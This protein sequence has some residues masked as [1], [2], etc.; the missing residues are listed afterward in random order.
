MH[1]LFYK[2]PLLADELARILAVN[3]LFLKRCGDMQAEL[4]VLDVVRHEIDYQAVS[5]AAMSAGDD[6]RS[7]RKAAELQVVGQLRQKG[8]LRDNNG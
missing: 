7:Q 5:E 4:E 1:T 8:I 6:P 3:G 2:P